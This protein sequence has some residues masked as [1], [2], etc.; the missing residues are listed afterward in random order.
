MLREL[1]RMERFYSDILTG[2][3]QTGHFCFSRIQDA[4][5]SKWASFPQCGHFQIDSC[6]SDSIR[7]KQMI[8]RSSV[9]FHSFWIR[10]SNLTSLLSRILLFSSSTG[11]SRNQT[12]FPDSLGVSGIFTRTL[13]RNWTESSN[14]VY[15]I[16]FSNSLILISKLT[17]WPSIVD[18][19][20]DILAVILWKFS[21]KTWPIRLIVSRT[22]SNSVRIISNE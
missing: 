22:S 21:R 5:W 18:S 10:S 11:L 7:L 2:C 13:S 9:H 3:R 20:A 12:F 8:Q 1:S 4:T 14:L 15:S 6:V 16:L 19:S 17:V